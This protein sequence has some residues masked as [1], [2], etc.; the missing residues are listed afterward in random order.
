MDSLP[1][2]EIELAHR[3]VRR[4]E[5]LLFVKFADARLGGLLNYY[6]EM[7]NHN[8][9]KRCTRRTDNSIKKY[10]RK[11]ALGQGPDNAQYHN[12]DGREKLHLPRIWGPN[13]EAY[14]DSVGVLLADLLALGFPLLEN[15]IFFIL[16]L[17][18]A[19]RVN[20]RC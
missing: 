6:L 8:K 3:Q 15:I 20:D 17:H 4:Y 19:G 14:R 18:C 16:E 12:K 10:G 11:L 9:M 7:K 5:V 1:D 13:G 2:E